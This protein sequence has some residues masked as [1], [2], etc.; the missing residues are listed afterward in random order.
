MLYGTGKHTQSITSSV[1]V[2]LSLDIMVLKDMLG[3]VHE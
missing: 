2:Q 1:V 3:E